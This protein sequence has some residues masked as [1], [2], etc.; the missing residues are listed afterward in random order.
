MKT[1]ILN[2]ISTILASIIF[3][4]GM[5]LINIV[6]SKIASADVLELKEVKV[7]Y[8]KFLYARDP[9][10]TLGNPKE[11]LNIGIKTDLLGVFYW[12]S[13]VHGTT[14]NS[15]YRRVGLQM[16]LGVRL[17][18]SLEF[19]YKHHS[20]HILDANYP[21]RQEG[22]PDKFPVE[23]SLG[24]NIYLFKANKERSIF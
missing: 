18:N 12:H 8:K 4:F 16:N 1:V 7:E 13:F 9:L 24:I 17:F 5:L 23:D 22:A 2:I 11:Q 20:Q 21:Y 14:D 6:I 19:E 10:F 15:Q 3:L